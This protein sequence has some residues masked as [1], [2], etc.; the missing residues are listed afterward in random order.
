MGQMGFHKRT[1]FNQRILK[2]SDDAKDINKDGWKN[3]G[4]IKTNYILIKGS[5]QGPAKRLI[6]LKPA[7]RP[8]N[9]PSEPEITN[10]IQ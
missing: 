1:Q 2:I 6:R 4:L 10:I 7:S 3:Y 8:K 5:I 9:S